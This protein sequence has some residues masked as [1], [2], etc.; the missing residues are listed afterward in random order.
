MTTRV[1]S[2][3]ISDELFVLNDFKTLYKDL[4]LTQALDYDSL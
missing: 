1:R 4:A 3:I 2:F